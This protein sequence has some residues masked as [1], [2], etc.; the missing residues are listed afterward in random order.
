MS[1]STTYIYRPESRT[2]SAADKQRVRAMIDRC[3][4]RQKLCERR[5]IDPDRDYEMR[6]LLAEADAL[7][8]ELD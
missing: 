1:F 6:Q 4:A 3:E 8:R 5:H 2:P 7:V